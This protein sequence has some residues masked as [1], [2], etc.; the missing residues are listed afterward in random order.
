MARL[1]SIYRIKGFSAKT[2]YGDQRQRYYLPEDLNGKE[3]QRGQCGC[4]GHSRML[5]YKA[6][7]PW[8]SRWTSSMRVHKLSVCGKNKDKR[9]HCWEWISLVV[10]LTTETLTNIL[11]IECSRLKHKNER[12]VV[13]AEA[14]S[15]PRDFSRG[16]VAHSQDC[17]E[18]IERLARF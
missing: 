10:I 1:Q 14:C 15:Q 18:Q 6:A 3:P 2:V 5:E 4:I 16:S 17:P 9:S 7:R 8:W 13:K 12:G 11:N